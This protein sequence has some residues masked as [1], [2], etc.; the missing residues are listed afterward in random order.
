MVGPLRRCRVLRGGSGPP[1]ARRQCQAARGECLLLRDPGRRCVAAR[2]FSRLG[3]I[4]PS[5]ALDGWHGGPVRRTTGPPAPDRTHPH[6]HRSRSHPGTRPR[7]GPSSS[8]DR[9]DRGIDALA[10]ILAQR[11]SPLE[12]AP[13]RRLM[14]TEPGYAGILRRQISVDLAGAICSHGS[15]LRVYGG[16]PSRPGPR[17]PS[18]VAPDTGDRREEDEPFIEPSRR[19]AAL[20]SEVRWQSSRTPVTVPKFENPG[21]M[22]ASRLDIPGQDPALTGADS[23]GIDRPWSAELLEPGV[24]GVGYAAAGFPP[25]RTRNWRSDASA[26]AR[27]TTPALSEVRTEAPSGAYCTM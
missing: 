7:N 9:R 3:T 13:H 22:V 10:D 21:F 25:T 5:R 27:W 26:G 1:R 16:S 11:Q 8:G 4:H 12:T 15:R 17:Y 19:M 18:V 23:P 6:G 20:W 14:E 2:R 24:D